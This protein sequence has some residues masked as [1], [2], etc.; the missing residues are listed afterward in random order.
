MR[1]AYY[2]DI[3]RRVGYKIMEALERSDFEEKLYLWFFYSDD[4]TDKIIYTGID[5]VIAVFVFGSNRVRFP[6][7]LYYQTSFVFCLTFQNMVISDTV[8]VSI[9]DVI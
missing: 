2:T 8:F 3:R 1:I 6:F 9:L 7:S 5:S 4:S